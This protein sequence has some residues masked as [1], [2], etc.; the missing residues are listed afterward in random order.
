M[1]KESAKM[2]FCNTTDS[3]QK[4]LFTSNLKILL[5]YKDR[6]ILFLSWRSYCITMLYLILN[7]KILSHYHDASI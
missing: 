7:L 5:H 1:G 3:K 4:Y 2:T 6:G